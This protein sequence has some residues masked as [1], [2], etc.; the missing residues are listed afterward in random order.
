MKILYQFGIIF[1]ICLF[2]QAVAYF[3][4][5]KFPGSVIAMVVLFVLLISKLIKEKDIELIA[6]YIMSNMAFFF[7]PSGV[8]LIEY[9][10]VLKNV[11]VQIIIICSISFICVF[12]VSSYSVQ[13]TLKLIK[14]SK[15]EK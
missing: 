11:I 5:F 8:L 2:G 6:D 1:S 15:E 9:F 7:I 10:A 3:L 4:P 14:H 13:L 12:F